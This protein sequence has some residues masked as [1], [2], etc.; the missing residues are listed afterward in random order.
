MSPVHIGGASVGV[1][2]TY[3]HPFFPDTAYILGIKLRSP[4]FEKRYTL[5][6][7]LHQAKEGVV[8]QE[9][10]LAAKYPQVSVFPRAQPLCQAPRAASPSN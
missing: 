10:T 2:T 7:K 3:N 8:V 4:F 9:Q 5:F 6:S 1:G